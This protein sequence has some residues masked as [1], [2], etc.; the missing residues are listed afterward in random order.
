MIL[1]LELT[2]LTVIHIFS[3]CVCVCA[4]VATLGGC[5]Q[6]HFHFGNISPYN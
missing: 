5:H 4:S 3:L 2:S 1:L 6:F